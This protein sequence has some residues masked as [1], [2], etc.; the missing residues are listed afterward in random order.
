MSNTLKLLVAWGLKEEEHGVPWTRT[1]SASPVFREGWRGVPGTR[2]ELHIKKEVV[3]K[4]V[5]KVSEIG[6]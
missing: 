5:T 3:M 1:Y 6:C 4:N 2:T